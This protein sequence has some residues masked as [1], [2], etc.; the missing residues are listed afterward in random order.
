[1][2][3]SNLQVGWF[4]YIGNFRHSYPHNG[5]MVQGICDNLLQHHDRINGH[6]CFRVCVLFKSHGTLTE[7]Q[8]LPLLRARH[9]RHEIPQDRTTAVYHQLRSVFSM[10]KYRMDIFKP[11]RKPGHPAPLLWR[12]HDI[13]ASDDATAQA[14]AEDLYRTHASERTLTSFYLCDSVGRL[15]C[16]SVK[17][18]IPNV[19]H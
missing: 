9:L 6:R 15:I 5:D 3:P 11:G 13:Y 4:S 18:D 10:T 1:V 17:K 8:F 7:G 12:R 16:E 19:V 2:A 14:K